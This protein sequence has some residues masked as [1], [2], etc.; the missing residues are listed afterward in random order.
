MKPD[1]PQCA[2]CPYDWSERICRTGTG[3]APA[4]CPTLRLRGQ[5]KTASDTV[6]ADPALLK[7]SCQASLQEA[8][9]YGGREKGYAAIRPIKPRLLEVAEFA[10]RMGYTRLGL[11]F[12]GGLRSEAAAVHR[13][14]ESKGFEVASLMCKSGAVPKS[15]IGV[16]RQDQVD[17]TTES[18]TMCNPVFQ[19]MAA[20]ASEVDFNILLGLC[21]GHDSLFIRFAEAPVTVL[22]VKDRLLGHNPLA[23]V[24]QMD[25]YYRY[26]KS[27]PVGAPGGE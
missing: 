13:F 14:L 26:L 15:D 6:K 8:A 19:A 12:C 3:K 23:A 4:N 27:E 20:N 1:Y 7:F 11:A 25:H 16:S 18:E 5:I 9:G 17:P 2:I 22:A 24:Y 21:V 10:A